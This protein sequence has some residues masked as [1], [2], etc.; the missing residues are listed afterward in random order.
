MTLSAAQQSRYARHLSLEAIGE[1][2]QERLLNGRV[3]IV[4]LGGLGSPIA[5]YLAAA[6]IGTIGIIDADVVDAS[7]LQ[8]QV[9]YTTDDVGSPKATVATKR[10]TALNPDATVIAQQAWFT[11]DNA[12]ILVANYDAVVDA[13]DNFEAKFLIADACHRNS[14]PYSHAG[15]DQFFGQTITVI[16]G[17]TACYRC[18]FE[19]PPAETDAPPSGPLGVVPGLIG[20]VQA[21]EI[22]KLL[23]GTGD[24]L[25]NQLFTYEA[26]TSAVRRITVKRNP[27]CP[28]C[29]NRNTEFEQ[30]NKGENDDNIQ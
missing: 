24:L 17:Q 25:T 12:D 13:T 29:G 14:I 5:L 9:L 30:H 23:T 8:R 2:G 21:N 6:G 19:A 7:N 28:L 18:L 10:L 4:G 16:P 3:L 26:Q 20:T 11:E 27:D 1:D 22:I 15:V